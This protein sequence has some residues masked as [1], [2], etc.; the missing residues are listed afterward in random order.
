MNGLRH[1]SQGGHRRQPDGLIYAYAR[2][3]FGKPF[4]VVQPSAE[5]WGVWVT[6]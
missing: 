3:P 4:V 1:I 5:R 2:D 6:A